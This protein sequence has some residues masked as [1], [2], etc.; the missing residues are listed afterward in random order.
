MTR[1][2]LRDWLHVHLATGVGPKRFSMLLEA[3]GS[4]AKILRASV[5]QLKDIVGPATGMLIYEGLKSVDA[6]AELTEV[7]NA[8][9][10]LLTVRDA[11]Y[12]LLLASCP[13]PPAVLYVKGELKEQDQLSLA[14]VGT[15]N[16]TR[17]GSDQAYR[18]S[19]LLA[20]AGIT[21]VSGL[22]RGIDGQAHRGALLAKGRTI[23]VLGSGLGRIYPPEHAELA[24]QILE[25][26]GAILSEYPMTFQPQAGNFPA[27]NRIVAGMTLGTFVVEAPAQSGALITAALAIEYNREAFALPGPVDQPNFQGCHQLIKSGK[28]K[29]VTSLEDILDELGRVG[30]ILKVERTAGE[31]VPDNPGEALGDLLKASLSDAEKAIWDFLG[32]GA[33]DLDTICDLCSLPAAQVS[34]SLTTLQLKGLI[35]NL[36]GNQFCRR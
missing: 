31:K 19:Y 27:R 24:E 32:H 18:L 4:P 16:P 8:G 3:L 21:V 17:Y 11:E 2:E 10:R 5:G 13:D 15:R 6:E 20:Q 30:Q 14:V 23:A 34:A 29:L 22:A 12:P 28:A 33:N 26:G 36:P 7:R 1:E 25:H 9:V 35:K